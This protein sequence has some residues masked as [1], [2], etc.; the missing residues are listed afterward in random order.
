M[1]GVAHREERS[2]ARWRTPVRRVS[3]PPEAAEPLSGALGARFHGVYAPLHTHP[4]DAGKAG[5]KARESIQNVRILCGNCAPSAPEGDFAA[6]R[7]CLRWRT[8]PSPGAP[9]VRPAVRQHS[10]GEAGERA[11]EEA[12]GGRTR[13]GESRPTGESRRR[14]GRASPTDRPDR[15]GLPKR[16]RGDGDTPSAS[17]G[18]HP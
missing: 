13:S 9:A 14:V 5:R 16:D 15:H 4:Q 12:T 6:S 8:G 18:G 7:G 3:Q 17:D 2:A 1:A 11:G 10:T